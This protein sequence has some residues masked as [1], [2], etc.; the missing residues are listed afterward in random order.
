MHFS[1]H[2]FNLFLGVACVGI[3]P[4]ALGAT[5]TLATCLE[6]GKT[7]YASRQLPQA[8][9]TFE[10]CLQLDDKNAET[11]LSL[12]GVLLTQ[13]NLSAAQTHF[14]NA[15]KYMPR[16]SPYWSY[17][18]SMLG[19][20][21]L[22][23]KN[24]KQ[25]LAMYGKSLEYN[26]ANVN[27]LIGKG[28]ILETQG[29]KQ[30]A[31]EM[32]R[33]AV[34]VEPLNLIARQR[35]IS[36]E[37]DYFTDEEMLTALKQRY[38]IKPETTQLTSQ[39]RELFTKIHR[40]EQRRGIDYL[41]NKYGR[42]TQDFIVTLNK[43]TDFER[44]ML[45]LQGFNTLEKNMGQ[46]A[47]TVFG[48]HHVPVQMIFDLRDKHGNPVFTP[49][50]T[51]TEE[52][53]YVYTQALAGKKEYLLPN[54][55]VPLTQNQQKKADARARQLEQKGYI[56]ISR[57][58]LKMLETETLCSEETL[59]DK[60]GVY[61]LPVAKK[62]WRYFVLTKDEDALKTIAYFYVMT[63]RKK[64]H[65]NIEVPS[66]ELVSYYSYYGYTVCLSDG[67]LTLPSNNETAK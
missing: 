40:A 56:E 66:N 14:E 17:T 57:S 3:V 59:K 11:Y 67:N 18:Y 29:N 10:R 12:A 43:G 13:N 61:Y 64:R 63:A 44:E 39:H 42:H 48:K 52:G 4:H 54:Q 41:K 19:D 6:E 62:Q 31:A 9:H 21:A 53:F 55:P 15:L 46:D 23:Q 5:Q 27:S 28:V 16:T 51:L 24:H 30:G 20:I 2:Y 1:R 36:L 25:A 32:Y 34:A 47:V 49:Q 60:L 58:E 22:K 33:A 7:Y 26:R 65:P 8:Q 50:S 38:A 45:T 35:L 37:P